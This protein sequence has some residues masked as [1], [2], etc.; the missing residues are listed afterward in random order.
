MNTLPPE[1]LG[2]IFSR[3]DLCITKFVCKHWKAI[4]EYCGFKRIYKQYWLSKIAQEGNFQILIWAIENGCPMNERVLIGAGIGGNVQMVEFLREVDCPW[5]DEISIVAARYGN[6]NLIRHLLKLNVYMDWRTYS[7][8][9][10]NGY[11]G[12]LRVLH[13]AEIPWNWR[14]FSAAAGSGRIDVVN[15]LWTQGC[16][17]NSWVYKSPASGG[18]LDMVS[19]LHENDCP[20]DSEATKAAAISGAINVLEYM[21]DNGCPPHYELAETAARGGHVDTIKFLERRGIDLNFNNI[22][23]SFA[24]AGSIAGIEWCMGK[25]YRVNEEISEAALDA[26]QTNLI[27]WMVSKDLL[28]VGEEVQPTARIFGTDLEMVKLVWPHKQDIP[29]FIMNNAAQ[30][31]GEDIIN[32]MQPRQTYP[33]DI[34]QYAARSGDIEFMK[35][36]LEVAP[37]ANRE[38]VCCNATRSGSKRMLNWV[39]KNPMFPHCSHILPDILHSFDFETVR[40][41]YKRGAPMNAH[42]GYVAASKGRMDVLKWA[43]EHDCPVDSY[44]FADAASN[45]YL[46]IM[47]WLHSIGCDW[48]EI[49]MENAA[50]DQYI[51][52]LDWLH[53]LEQECEFYSDEYSEAEE[54]DGTDVETSEEPSGESIGETDGEE[55]SS[56]VYEAMDEFIFDGDE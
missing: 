19:W 1:V 24:Y 20:W 40:K 43:V 14:V 33:D 46:Q 11:F 34:Y 28:V 31:R 16:N 3:T 5:T 56:E 41:Y 50:Q 8:A 42:L 22:M 51:E 47:Q 55:D 13:R 37:Y 4:I 18:D 15:W 7:A 35:K 10:W 17:Y 12:I 9:A 38:H 45:G 52:V 23:I 26:S 32:H 6:T 53:T 49:S 25:G 29:D 39:F 2:L 48:D 36:I 27:N 21:L 30:H 44:T 54:G